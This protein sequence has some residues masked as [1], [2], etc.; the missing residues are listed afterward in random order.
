LEASYTLSKLFWTLI[1]EKKE[2]QIVHKRN[3]RWHTCSH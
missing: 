1:R 3:F 2:P